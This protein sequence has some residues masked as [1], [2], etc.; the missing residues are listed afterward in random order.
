MKHSRAASYT[1]E[2]K[3]VSVRR[4]AGGHNDEN[5]REARAACAHVASVGKLRAEMAL[6]RGGTGQG[7]EL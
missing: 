7:V 5:E 1:H 4:V 3:R 6:W 2:A